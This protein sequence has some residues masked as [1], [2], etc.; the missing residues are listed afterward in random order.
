MGGLIAKYDITTLFLMHK[1]DLLGPA[2]F[3]YADDS[4]VAGRLPARCAG[5]N[6]G[7]D[8]IESCRGAISD[9]FR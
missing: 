6:V 8:D 7:S 1:N 2:T 3:G 9:S 5:A 4:T